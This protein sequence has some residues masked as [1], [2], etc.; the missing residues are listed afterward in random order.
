M[1]PVGFEPTITVGERPQSYVLDCAVTGIGNCQSLCYIMISGP[2]CLC[3]RYVRL[4]RGLSFDRW[5]RE[6]KWGNEE[7]P[8]DR[9]RK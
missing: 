1:P 9:P 5:Y 7:A 4:A 8:H 6:A 2:T 3:I